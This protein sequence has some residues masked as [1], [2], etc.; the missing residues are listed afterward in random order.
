MTW[1]IGRDYWQD[2]SGEYQFSGSW[3]GYRRI[4]GRGLT[5]ETRLW[6]SIGGKWL[7]YR[8]GK[9][10]PR[11]WSAHLTICHLRL[12]VGHGSCNS[13]VDA[14]RRA[15]KALTPEL[16]DQLLRKFYSPQN[17]RAVWKRQI[18]YRPWYSSPN[19]RP[20]NGPPEMECTRFTDVGYMRPEDEPRG[21]FIVYG[22]RRSDEASTEEVR[23]GFFCASF[24]ARAEEEE[25][26]ATHNWLTAY[27]EE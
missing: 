13:L 22:K 12:E 3:S 6:I 5:T 21:D 15:D 19:D 9:C 10:R 24:P 18:K 2:I 27:R 16:I 8:G 14:Q 17:G 11:R 1:F 20:V 23:P 7:F 25:L 26:A 4:S